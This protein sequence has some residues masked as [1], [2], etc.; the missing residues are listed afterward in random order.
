MKKLNSF[1]LLIFLFTFHSSISQ[2]FISQTIVYDGNIREYE[3][4]IPENYSNSN[5]VPLLFNFHGGGGTAADQIYLSD[6]RSLADQ[7]NFIL[8][9]PQAIADPTDNGSL[10]WI[11]KGDSDHD[12][13]YF[14]EALIDELSSQYTVDPKRVYACGYSL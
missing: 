11:F 3:L 9:Y 12:D 6:M 14:V 1:Y 4:Y 13:I 5:E 8:V 2:D 10:N 7:N